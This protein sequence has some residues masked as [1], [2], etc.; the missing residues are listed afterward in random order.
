MVTV[1]MYNVKN[2]TQ[3]EQVTAI[4]KTETKYI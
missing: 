3:P 4:N 2:T 1:K